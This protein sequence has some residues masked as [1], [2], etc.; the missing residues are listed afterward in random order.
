MRLFVKRFAGWIAAGLLAIS[1]A[2]AFVASA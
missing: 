1:A 2:G